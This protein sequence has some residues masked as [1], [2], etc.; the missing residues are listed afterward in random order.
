[1]KRKYK[2]PSKEEYMMTFSSISILI[3]FSSIP[4]FPLSN[5]IAGNLTINGPQASV[6]LTS[7]GERE[8]E[9]EREDCGTMHLC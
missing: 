8:R 3:S 5:L 1:M 7:K 4:L 6:K 9:R 2:S